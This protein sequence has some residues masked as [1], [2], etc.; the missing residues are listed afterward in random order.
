MPSPLEDARDAV[1]KRFEFIEGAEEAV[2]ALIAA[3]K[4]EVVGPLLELVDR[5]TTKDSIIWDGYSIAFTPSLAKA[6]EAAVV[7]HRDTIIE[8][9]GAEVRTSTEDS[10]G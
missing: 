4:A 2:D 3:A 5:L 10:Q 1:L 8:R 7:I 9:R 6:I